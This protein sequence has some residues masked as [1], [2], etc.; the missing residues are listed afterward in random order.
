[1]LKL[2]KLFFILKSWC[3]I[4]EDSAVLL[5]HKLGEKDREIELLKAQLA[6]VNVQKDNLLRMCRSVGTLYI[7]GISSSFAFVNLT[8]SL[9]FLF[10]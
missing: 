2:Y 9:K 10:I 3:G 5:R 6:L 7:S 4:I 8:F 1:M